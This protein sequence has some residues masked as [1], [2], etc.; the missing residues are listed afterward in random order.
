MAAKEGVHNLKNKAEFDEALANKD[1]LLVLDCFATWCG[2]CKVIAPQVVKFSDK[3]TD[4]RFFKLDVD[5]VPD[6]AQELAVRAMP[7]FLLFK[8]G[9]KVGEVVGANP[10]A[11]EAAIKQNV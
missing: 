9:E 7:T 4:A 1:T 6:V 11:L 8:N 10:T 5:E 2:P 3:Y